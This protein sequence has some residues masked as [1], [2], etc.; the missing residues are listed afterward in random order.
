MKKKGFISLLLVALLL[1][2]ACGGGAKNNGASGNTA[3][4]NGEANVNAEANAPAGDVRSSLKVGYIT[5]EGGINDGSFNQGVY[6]GLMKAQNEIDGVEFSYIESKDSNVFKQNFETLLD[7]G[8]ELVIGAGFK[9]GDSIY[10]EAIANPDIK[11]A[12]VD[13]DPAA[14]VDEEGNPITREIPENLIGLMFRAEEPSFLVGYIAGMTTQTNKV[15]F[16]GGQE[17][18]LILAFDYG[19]RAGV[20]Y[21]AK[22]LGKQIEVLVQYVGD[23]SD[24]AKGKAIAN[25]MYSNG[26]DV[27]YHA[28]GGAGDGVI[29]SAKE[30]NKWA[31]G[32]DRDQ[33]EDAPDN[34]LTS[35]MKNANIV[36]QQI[37]QDTVDGKWEGGKT[38]T[39]GLKDEGAVGVAPS[40]SKHVPQEIL[41]KVDEISKKIVAGEIVVPYDEA[42]YTEQ[43][44]K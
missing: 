24:S 32:V 41:D 26:A 11:Y 12:I 20:D 37:V 3:E 42:T 10:E 33:I 19:Y 5:D 16:V 21:A 27:V 2:S 31:I 25:Q 30:V 8:A 43:F 34:M 39:Y 29:N 1:L 13:V 15:G 14:A 40:S 22:E 6:E 7:G 44:S 4:G 28:A 35:A 18:S 9:L 38:I 23:F 17:T 36:V